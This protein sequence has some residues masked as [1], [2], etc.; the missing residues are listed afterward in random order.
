MATTESSDNHG[1]ETG[2]ARRHDS[3]AAHVSAGGLPV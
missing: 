1:T 2:L 3:M